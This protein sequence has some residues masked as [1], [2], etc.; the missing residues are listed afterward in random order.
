MVKSP[1][2]RTEDT[3]S[4][5]GPCRSPE[6]GNGTPVQFSC[7]EDLRDRG[8]WWATVHRGGHKELDMTETDHQQVRA[9]F[10]LFW[11]LHVAYGTLV[12]GPGIEPR[13]SVSEK[14][15]S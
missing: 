5:P 12:P 8:A 15:K 4:I 1:P 14:A 13:P 2:A 7:L 10:D 6:E 9:L 11:L 3:G